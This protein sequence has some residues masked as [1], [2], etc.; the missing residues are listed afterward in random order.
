MIEHK[1]KNFRLIEKIGTNVLSWKFRA[2]VDMYTTE[3]R[4]F[5][6]DIKKITEVEVYKNYGSSWYFSDT[7]QFT[8]GL[9][10]ENL[11]RVFEA[12]EGTKLENCEVH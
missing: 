5:L 3:K 7:G 11:E 6:K 2:L 12:S 9:E 4:L 10:I 1:F 8:P